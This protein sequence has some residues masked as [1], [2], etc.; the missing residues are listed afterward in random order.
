MVMFKVLEGILSDFLAE[1][2]SEDKGYRVHTHARKMPGLPMARILLKRISAP[3]KHQT[4][5]G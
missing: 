1:P 2:V 4:G 5:L 3:S